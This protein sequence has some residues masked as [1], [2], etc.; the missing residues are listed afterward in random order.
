MPEALA[1]ARPR[2]ITRS[3]SH[4]A[5]AAQR[6]T[7]T[8]PV[9]LASAIPRTTRTNTLAWSLMSTLPDILTATRATR[10]AGAIQTASSRDLIQPGLFLIGE[11]AGLMF[12]AQFL[13]CS[14]Q[15]SDVFSALFGSHR[16]TSARFVAK[17]AERLFFLSS[18]AH[19]DGAEHGSGDNGLEEDV[20]FRFHVVS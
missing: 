12:R 16:S 3:V 18:K 17:R 1:A 2:A 19:G 13:K 5:A 14:L 7:V 10:N 8:R 11:G 15:G 9:T 4:P 20:C 6:R